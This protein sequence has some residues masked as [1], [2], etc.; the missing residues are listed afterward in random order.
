MSDS[1]HRT[2][3]YYVFTLPGTVRFFQWLG[4]PGALA[5][6]TFWTL[7]KLFNARNSQGEYA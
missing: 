4:L 1:T 3:K 7:S 2:P 6:P 5:S